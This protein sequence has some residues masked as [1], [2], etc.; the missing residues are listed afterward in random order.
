MLLLSFFCLAKQFY[1]AMK[2]ERIYFKFPFQYILN[3]YM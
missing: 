1:E 2:Q 3:R